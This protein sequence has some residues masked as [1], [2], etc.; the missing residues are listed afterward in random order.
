MREFK[1]NSFIYRIIL[2]LCVNDRNRCRDCKYVKRGL[3]GK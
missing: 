1:R 2:V 3:R